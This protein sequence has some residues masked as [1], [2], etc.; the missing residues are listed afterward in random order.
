MWTQAI[1]AGHHP[2]QYLS[3]MHSPH[4]FINKSN[5]FSFLLVTG[6]NKI[7]CLC[8]VDCGWLLILA[9]SS[10]RVQAKKW[11]CH[12]HDF[13]ILLSYTYIKSS[14]FRLFWQRTYFPQVSTNTDTEHQCKTSLLHANSFQ[15]L[16]EFSLSLVFLVS[17]LSGRVQS[18]HLSPSSLVLVL[19]L[20]RQTC[21]EALAD[22]TNS[23]L[24]ENSAHRQFHIFPG[25]GQSCSLLLSFSQPAFIQWVRAR[26]IFTVC[27]SNLQRFYRISINIVGLEGGNI[28]PSF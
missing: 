17:G 13:P 11:R 21:N 10:R 5:S 16:L 2:P 24:I 15:K 14:N 19:V 28:S 8:V 1:T 20:P 27:C 4:L 6:F 12:L 23:S 9:L 25:Q 7:F 3:G 26:C 22:L 18:H